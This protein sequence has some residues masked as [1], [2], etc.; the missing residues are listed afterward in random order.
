MGE[1]V[2]DIRGAKL[3]LQRNGTGAP[4]LYLHGVQGI[5]GW[6][7]ALERLAQRFDVLAPDHP[8]FGGSDAP[9][10]IADVG[11][12]AFFYLDV[13]EA[14]QLNSVH[15][16]GASLGG[17]IAMEMAIRSTARIES[18]T[19]TG[20]AGIRVAGV[21]RG[22]MFIGTPAELGRLLFADEKVAAE[23]AVQ[24][25]ATPALQESYDRNRYAAAKY[26]WQ[27]RLYNPK[28]ATW[29]HRI[30]VPTHIVWGESDRLIPPAH[31]TALQSLIKGAQ[32]TMLPGS[33]H[34]VALEQP[35][36][37]ADTVAQ[38]IERL[39]P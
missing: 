12:L 6:P 5:L 19:L 18:L 23:R 39:R 9:D 16:V 36:L 28:L 17:W 25:Q 15:L 10:W 35:Q 4:L 27:P 24:W 21:P 13:L 14:L 31:A 22:D 29:L 30:A 2:V 3:R 7:P 37:F 34:L 33:G 20:A 11:D 38:F 8:G 1:T 32:L 26:T